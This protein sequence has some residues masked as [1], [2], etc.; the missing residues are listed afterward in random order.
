MTWHGLNSKQNNNPDTEEE[1]EQE[2]PLF[3]NLIWTQSRRVSRPAHKISDY[4]SK[5]L[6][7]SSNQFG[8]RFDQD[9]QGHCSNHLSN[10]SPICPDI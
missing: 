10:E 2:D 9:D 6:A 7:I 5:L 3:D 1:Q 8:Q 4:T